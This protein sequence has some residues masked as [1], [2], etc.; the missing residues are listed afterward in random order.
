MVFRNFSETES[1]KGRGGREVLSASPM[2][3]LWLSPTGDWETMTDPVVTLQ[4]RGR[5]W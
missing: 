3:G 5:C 1:A 2:Q 4:D